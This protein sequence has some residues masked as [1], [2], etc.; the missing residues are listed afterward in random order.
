MK[1]DSGRSMNL[2]SPLVAARRA[3]QVHQIVVVCRRRSSAAGDPIEQIGVGAIEKGFEL[4]ELHGAKPVDAAIRKRAE[5]QVDLLS[6]AVPAAKQKALSADFWIA[7][8][9]TGV[10]AEISHDLSP[11]SVVVRHRPATVF[12]IGSLSRHGPSGTTFYDAECDV[13]FI[14]T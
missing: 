7:L 6:A 14:Q 11:R 2:S 9:Q 5:D 10:A 4:I 1:G 8:C 12:A 13:E 3:Q